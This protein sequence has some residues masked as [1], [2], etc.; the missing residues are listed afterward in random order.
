V[1]RVDFT[2]TVDNHA[3]DHRLRVHFPTPIQTDCS[4]AEG[5]FDVVQRPL[6]LPED[7]ADWVEQPVPTH[8]QR[9]FVDVNDGEK[10]LMVINNGLPEYEVVGGTGGVT[11]ALTLLRCVGWLSRGDL[12]SRRGNAGPAVETP[13]AQCLGKQVFDYV[14]VPHVGG[15]DTC[16]EQAHAFNAPLRAVPTIVHSGRL[17]PELSFVQIEPASL[18]ISAIKQAES[19]EGLIVRF[20]NTAAEEVKGRLKVYRLFVRAALVNLNEEET[21]ELKSNE[22]GEVELS[23]RGKQIVTVK[24]EF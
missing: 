20:Y 7:T 21:E 8:P 4:H 18:V 3:R 24:F 5:H 11:V 15:W 14:I 10:G 12:P 1:R 13:G 9:T 22:R 19:G 6:D 23:A 17:P 2:T 16:L